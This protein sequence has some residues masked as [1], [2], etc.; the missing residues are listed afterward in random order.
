MSNCEIIEPC[1][2]QPCDAV[3]EVQRLLPNGRMWSLGRGDLIARS[4]LALAEVK[5]CVNEAICQE[6]AEQN[7]CTAV[8]L[9]DYWARLYCFPVE[10]V[11]RERFC[12]WVDLM[13]DRDCPI[14]SIGFYK[15]VIEFVAPN[16]GITLTVQHPGLLAGKCHVSDP[17]KPERSVLCVSAP[18]ECF[19]WQQGDSDAQDGENQRCYFIPE[20]ECLRF[21]VFP[22]AS[23]G[24]K[25]DTANPNGSPIFNVP[26][27]NVDVKPEFYY[28]PK[29]LC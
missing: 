21:Y 23:L 4:F 8:R 14:G 13:E 25:T 22:F 12:D 15:K 18:P 1:H 29:R 26:D 27:A 6:W 11:E 17:A 2:T 9:F 7:P 3:D 10:C 24:Y 5:Q 19:Y 20:I 16:K 28:N